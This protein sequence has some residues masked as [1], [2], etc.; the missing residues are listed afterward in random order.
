MKFIDRVIDWLAEA[1]K[2][3]EIDKDQLKRIGE[4]F[5]FVTT[6]AKRIKE[7]ITEGK[8]AEKEIESIRDCIDYEIGEGKCWQCEEGTEYFQSCFSIQIKTLYDEQKIEILSKL[9]NQLRLE[10]LL[11][12]KKLILKD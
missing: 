2:D 7:I 12:I 4:I 8:L 1:I 10:D 11:E 6:G 3:E 5:S 9:F